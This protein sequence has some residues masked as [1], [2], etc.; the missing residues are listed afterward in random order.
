MFIYSVWLAHN[1]KGRTCVQTTFKDGQKYAIH[2]ITRDV[3]TIC[4]W[5][6]FAQTFRQY[7]NYGS[8]RNKI[9]ENIPINYLKFIRNITLQFHKSKQQTDTKHIYLVTKIHTQAR[10][11]THT[12]RE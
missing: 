3:Y 2:A 12:H 7:R 11:C 5:C 9:I 4:V 6:V 10:E 8:F 1:T